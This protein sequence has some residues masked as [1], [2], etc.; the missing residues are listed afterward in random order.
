MT[1]GPTYSSWE[2]KLRDLTKKRDKE[3]EL[4]TKKLKELVKRHIECEKE[5]CPGVL[6][7]A[8]VTRF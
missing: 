5:V 3:S 7:H 8:V 2:V 1:S 6:C 4:A